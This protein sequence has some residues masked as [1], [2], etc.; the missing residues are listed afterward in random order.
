[1]LNYRRLL[2]GFCLL[3]SGAAAF[4]QAGGTT[5]APA[6]SPSSQPS[7][8]PS[9]QPYAVEVWSEATFGPDG[10]LQQLEVVKTPELTD[11][12]VQRVRSQLAQARIPPVKDASGTPGTFQT[13]VL[14]VYQVTPAA[15]GGTV[16][17]QGMRLEPRPLKRYA[18]SEPEG[19]PANTPLV[20]R[21]QCEVDT[22]G[23]CAE[24]K[25]LEATGTS[26][27]L[28]RWALASARGWE[29]QPQRLNGQALPATVQLT[30]ELTIQD[31]RPADFR[32]PLRL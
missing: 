9:T 10:R 18:A 28:R 13:G 24:A 21:V 27:V 12:F 23:R 6:A 3:V 15:A 8:P 22:Q 7:T 32:N 11:A 2:L 30:L 14:T 25:V 31:L 17:L 1:M 26:D 29:F 4:S 20:A 16:R 19:L 5:E